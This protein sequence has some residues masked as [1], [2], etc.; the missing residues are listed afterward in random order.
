[1]ICTYIRDDDYT[2]SGLGMQRSS[3]GKKNLPCMPA[4]VRIVRHPFDG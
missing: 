1:M 2:P 3:S 4:S